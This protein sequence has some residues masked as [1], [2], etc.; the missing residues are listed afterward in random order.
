MYYESSSDEED[1]GEDILDTTAMPAADY[2][3]LT[4]M[5]LIVD[6]LVALVTA[7]CPAEPAALMASLLESGEWERLVPAAD[8]KAANAAAALSRSVNRADAS[9]YAVLG[10]PASASAAEIR[11]VYRQ[12]SKLT[13]PDRCGG[14]TDAFQRLSNA[15]ECLSDSQQ[16]RAYDAGL[17]GTQGGPWDGS[18]SLVTSPSTRTPESPLSR[19]GFLDGDEVARAQPGPAVTQ[20]AVEELLV[21]VVRELLEERPPES[22]AILCVV[23]FLRSEGAQFLSTYA[24]DVDSDEEAS[25]KETRLPAEPELEPEPALEPELE[26]EPALELEL[27]LEPEPAPSQLSRSPSPP[28]TSVQ[29]NGSLAAMAPVQLYQAAANGHLEVVRWHPTTEFGAT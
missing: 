24:Q 18:A 2:L 15:Y 16:R 21:E 7:E 23:N 8:M 17:V 20:Y 28:C 6:A 22:E 26:P 9:Y 12:R 29:S 14:S 1:Y 3:Q 4:R 19:A 5:E 10:A 11:A 13:H 27:E 25:T